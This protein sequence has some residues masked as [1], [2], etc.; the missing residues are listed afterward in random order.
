MKQAFKLYFLKFQSGLGKLLPVG[1][2]RPTEDKST[3]REHV[4]FLN[5]MRPTKDK[6][7]ARKPINLACEHVDPK[8]T[9]D[10]LDLKMRSRKKGL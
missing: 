7:A 5:G 2:I 8:L 10:V 6:P 3:A 1:Q 4:F 9:L